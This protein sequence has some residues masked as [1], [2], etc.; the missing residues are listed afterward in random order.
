[1]YVTTNDAGKLLL[2]LHRWLETA[3]Q[4]IVFV[5]QTLGQKHINGLRKFHL[6]HAKPESA[7]GQLRLVCPV[8]NL[9]AIHGFRRLTQ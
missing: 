5:D 7:T 3:V 1:M 4:S 2:D 9:I 6:I 8:P